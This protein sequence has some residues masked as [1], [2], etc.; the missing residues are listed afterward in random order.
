MATEAVA[1]GKPVV[2]LYPR[3]TRFPESSFMLGY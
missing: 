2:V 1:S 3:E